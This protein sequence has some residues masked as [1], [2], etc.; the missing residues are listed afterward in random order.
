MR[1]F[2][3]ISGAPDALPRS[4]PAARRPLRAQAPAARR[5]PSTTPAAMPSIPA[6]LARRGSARLPAVPDPGRAA[7]AAE[8]PPPPGDV[9]PLPGLEEASPIPGPAMPIAEP[10]AIDE[11]PEVE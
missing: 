2:I 5:A 1:T 4:P 7:P 6:R 3:F 8:S 9:P 10:A 11:P